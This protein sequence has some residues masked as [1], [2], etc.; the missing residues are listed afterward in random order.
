MWVIFL[1][2][3]MVFAI[4]ALLILYIGNKIILKMKKDQYEFD[5]EMINIKEEKEKKDV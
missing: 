3:V 2:S 1:V 5:K 4:I